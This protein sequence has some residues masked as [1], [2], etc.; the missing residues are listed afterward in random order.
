MMNVKVQMK[1]FAVA[2]VAI[3][4]GCEYVIP[5]RP[6]YGYERDDVACSDGWDNDRDGLS[7]CDDPDCFYDSIHCGEDRVE[8]YTLKPENTFERCHDQIDND[9]DGQYDCAD[10]GCQD[11]REAC[12]WMF[13]TTDETCSDGIDTDQDGRADCDD[14]K[15]YRG[16]FVTV[17]DGSSSCPA[18]QLGPE[19]SLAACMDGCDNDGNG[20]VD[21][22]DFGCSRELNGASPQAVQYCA[23]LSGAGGATS[24]SALNAGEDENTL[25]ACSDGV[26]NDGDSYVDCDDFDCTGSSAPPEV[27]QYCDEWAASRP[28]E[29][30]ESTRELCSNGIDDDEDGFTDCMDYSCTDAGRGAT[31]D[32]IEYC[33]SIMEVTFES[34][35]DGIDNDGNGYTD[36]ED[37]SCSEADDAEV[38]VACQ[39]SVWRPG[40]GGNRDEKIAEARA[41]CTDGVDNDGDGYADCADWDCSWNP[42][43]W[44]ASSGEHLVCPGPKVC[45]NY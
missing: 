15:C 12:C 22:D 36:C 43:L 24:S 3:L 41:Y 5:D 44:D 27:I 26:D 10:R 34:C 17:C 19:N 6:V 30:S 31:A 13:E 20:F 45:E 35:T 21:C 42:L 16:I 4:C 1:H 37:F 11:V 14:F 33:S 9:G 28:D 2:V 32:A 7:D 39:E 23:S 29:S 25:E 40:D 38:R 18:D 8:G